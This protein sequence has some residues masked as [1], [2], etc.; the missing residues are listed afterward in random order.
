MLDLKNNKPVMGVAV[1]AIIL[2]TSTYYFRNNIKALFVNEIEV[3]NDENDEESNSG[4][5][6]VNTDEESN[7]SETI[8]NIEL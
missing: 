1:L 4:E 2:T 3:I 8:I 5:Q 6:V 7:N